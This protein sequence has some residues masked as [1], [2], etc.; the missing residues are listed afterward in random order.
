MAVTRAL[1]HFC[2]AG[3]N[4]T[5]DWKRPVCIPGWFLRRNQVFQ[6]NECIVRNYNIV[7][8]YSEGNMN[9]QPHSEDFKIDANRSFQ[10]LGIVSENERAE[11]FSEIDESNLIEES[12]ERIYNYLL[13]NNRSL[14]MIKPDGID[15]CTCEPNE[16]KGIKTRIHFTLNDEYY[17]ISCTDIRWRAYIRNHRNESNTDTLNNRETYL[18]IGLTREPWNGQIW[19]IVVGLHVLPELHVDVDYNNL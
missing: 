9:N 17:N 14:I 15:Q 3:V 12:D 2:V 11:L 1:N 13:S 6:D 7:R 16:Y 18:T 19:P 4:Q 8:F 10:L 5:N